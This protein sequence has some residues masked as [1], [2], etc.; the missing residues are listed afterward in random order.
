MN[1]TDAQLDIFNKKDEVIL[2]YTM[3][4]GHLNIY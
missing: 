4:T 3:A 2:S 1:Y